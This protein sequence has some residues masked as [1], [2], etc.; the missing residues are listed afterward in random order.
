M[1]FGKLRPIQGHAAVATCRPSGSG[2]DTWASI[3]ALPWAGIW[4]VAGAALVFD[5]GLEPSWC[6][7]DLFGSTREGPVGLRSIVIE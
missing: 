2:R 1:G 3:W 5:V 7:L 4:A 6:F